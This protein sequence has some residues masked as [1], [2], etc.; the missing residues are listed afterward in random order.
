MRA[1]GTGAGGRTRYAL[2]AGLV[3]FGPISQARLGRQLGIEGAQLT[4]L[5]HRI[6]EHHAGYQHNGA[7]LE[8]PYG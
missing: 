1:N 8:H 5:L 4:A 2:L 3:E 7:T 6:L